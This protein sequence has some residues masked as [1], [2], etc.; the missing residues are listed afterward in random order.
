MMKE[1]TRIEKKKGVFQHF[2]PENPERRFLPPE[3][4]FCNKKNHASM[5][6]KNQQVLYTVEHVAIY[7]CQKQATSDSTKYASPKVGVNVNRLKEKCTLLERNRQTEGSI[8]FSSLQGHKVSRY[9]VQL[10]D[11]LC[12]GSRLIPTQK[13]TP[14]KP[15]AEPN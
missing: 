9:L 6:F 2:N 15:R 3:K 7:G 13:R 12:C 5:P 11:S 4:V 10:F 14:F 1:I 8:V